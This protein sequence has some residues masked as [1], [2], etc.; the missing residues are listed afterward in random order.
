MRRWQSDFFTARRHNFESVQTA[1]ELEL[2]I[3]SHASFS[4]ELS[5][6]IRLKRLRVWAISGSETTIKN[7]INRT[8]HYLPWPSYRC[9]RGP[10]VVEIVEQLDYSILAKAAP[11]IPT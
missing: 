8:S 11:S 2:V 5:I 1:I 4:I 10:G 7:I 6:K 9:L 3:I